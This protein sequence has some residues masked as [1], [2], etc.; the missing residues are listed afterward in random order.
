[1]IVATEVLH[2]M[3]ENPFPTK[4]EVSDITNAVIDGCAALMLSGETAIGKHPV[5]AIETM[6]Q[7][8]DAAEEHVQRLL[9]ESPRMDMAN[10]QEV[11]SS[12]IAE[13]CRGLPITKIVTVTR[14]G[15][16]AR[17]IA[18]RRPRQPILAVSDDPIAARSFQLYPGTEGIHVDIP[19][20]RTSTDHI[21]ACLH[22]LW[23]RKKIGGDDMILVSAVAYP[24][25]GNRMNILQTHQ[26]ADLA[27]T[28]GW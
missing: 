1:V 14:S 25:S 23:R 15:Y 5:R 17:T 16:A 13:I 7:V 20:S 26:V 21:A 18:A 2:S 28:L 4:A 24:K 3:I 11:M 19:F 8:A 12:A 27:A 6:R 9:A 10:V 22:E